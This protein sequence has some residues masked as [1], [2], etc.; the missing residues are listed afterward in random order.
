MPPIYWYHQHLNTGATPARYLA[1]N[2]PLLVTHLGQIPHVA[3]QIGLEIGAV[4]R[5]PVAG[6][7]RNQRRKRA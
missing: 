1:I 6:R 4:K 5:V 2:A 3:L 7:S